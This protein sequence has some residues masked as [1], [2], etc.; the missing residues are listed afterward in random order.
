MSA[1]TGPLTVT[2]LDVNWRQWRLEETLRY[3]IGALGSGDII[4]VPA[5]FETDG[6]SVPRMF[7]WLLPTWGSYS[8]AAAVH[9]FIIGH[10]EAGDPL[11][12][13]PDRL[14]CD[15]IFFDA[16]A[17]CGTPAPLRWLLYM[18]V[19]LRSLSVFIVASTRRS[20]RS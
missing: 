10:V 7:W 15:R 8:R 20:S 4:D 17:V 14:T 18:G 3:E 16:S 5:G 6:A 1:F 11:T 2:Q 19:R 9:D 13:A 12:N